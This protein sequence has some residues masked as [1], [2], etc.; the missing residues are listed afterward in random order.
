MKSV[1]KLSIKDWRENRHLGWD[2]FITKMRSRQNV[3]NVALDSAA[4]ERAEARIKAIADKR[5]EEKRT[6]KKPVAVAVDHKADDDRLDRLLAFKPAERATAFQREARGE[7]VGINDKVVEMRQRLAI[8]K[9]EEEEQRER[10]R[11]RW[12][13]IH[14]LQ[15]GLPQIGSDNDD[16][17]PVGGY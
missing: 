2:G 9:G 4:N 5:A 12:E 7:K 14:R 6:A 16:L 1:L 10:E 17:L 15:A 13:N 8:P 3:A 11:Q